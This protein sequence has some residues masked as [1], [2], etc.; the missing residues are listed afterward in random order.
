MSANPL[1][2]IIVPCY[3]QGHFLQEALTSIMAQ[4]YENWECI[5]VNDGSPDDTDAVAKKF[6]KLD[7]RF[8]YEKQKN[9]GLSSARNKGLAVAKGDFIQFL[10]ADDLL[11]EK[12]LEHNVSFVSNSV[13]IVVSGYRYFND[14]DGP[15]RQTMFG[16]NNFLPEVVITPHDKDD[17]VPLF[18]SRNPFVVCAPIYRR[19]LIHE[20]GGFTEALAAL[21]DWH[22]NLH[23]VL[24]GA[25][26]C[27]CGYQDFTK[28]LVRIHPSSMSQDSAH[29]FAN[30]H[31][32][33][34]QCLLLPNY[35]LSAN[36]IHQ[37]TGSINSALLNIFKSLAR[38]LT[39]PLIYKSLAKISSQNKLDPP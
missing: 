5:I 21:E 24:L 26:V 20:A 19:S 13:D 23:C 12:K 37:T 7:K 30:Y 18:M 6:V 3:K 36:E 9:S 15:S 1:I 8:I 14:A 31:K 34:L 17:L 22:L 28:V 38:N 4:T 16:I 11:E 35:P 39:P 25:S 33:R 27:H 29:M 32:F 10:D 2:S